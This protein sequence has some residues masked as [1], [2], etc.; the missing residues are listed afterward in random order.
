MTSVRE[1]ILDLVADFIE[2]PARAAATAGRGPRWCVGLAC[3]GVAGLSLYLSQ[4]LVR[5]SPL[6]PAS[7]LLACV[8]QAAAGVFMASLLHLL[9]E[10]SGGRGRV[11]SVFV[12]FGMSQLVW[13]LALPM[14]VLAAFWRAALPAYWICVT[15]LAFSAL[16]LRARS[17]RDHYGFAMGKAWLLVLFPYLAGLLLLMAALAL[18]AIGLVSA[19]RLSF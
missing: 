6:N 13:A 9:A 14:A 10:W 11:G 12:L 5:L 4:S 19:V 7:L 1:G 8:W 2:N 16:Y 3:F 17:L 15:V 18:L